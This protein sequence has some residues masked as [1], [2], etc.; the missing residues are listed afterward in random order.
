LASPSALTVTSRREPWRA[1]G[2][3]V[4]VTIT[5]ATFLVLRSSP[6][7]LTPRRSSIAC[8]LSAVNAELR[9]ESPVPLRPTTRP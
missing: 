9:K 5:A 6:R 7:V 4:V 2:R 1:N 8:R 3:S